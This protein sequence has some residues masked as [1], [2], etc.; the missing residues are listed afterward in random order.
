MLRDENGENETSYKPSTL[1][2]TAA[3]DY[4]IKPITSALAEFIKRVGIS[5]F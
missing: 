2:L 5:Q 4:G 1:A 3:G